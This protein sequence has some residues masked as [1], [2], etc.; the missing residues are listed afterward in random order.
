MRLLFVGDLTGNTGPAN[1]N[2]ELN[3]NLPSSTIFLEKKSIISRILELAIKTKKADAVLF[4]GMSKINI[5]GFKLAKLLGVK[6]AYLM[7]GCRSIE[8]KINGN[9]S[10]NDIDIENKVLE[11]APIIICVSKK[12]MYWMKENYPQYKEK[13]TYVNNGID[14]EQLNTIREGK[15]EREERTLM[16]VG[17]GVPLKNIKSI[18][19][20]IDLINR[21]DGM[22][23][24]LIV[25]G[26]DGKDLE[27]ILSFPFVQHYQNVPHDE[28][29]FYYQR[30]KLF[31]QNSSFETFGLAPIEALVNGCD[32]LLSQE[33]GV[34]S[35]ITTL[36]S[37]D[38]IYNNH[39]INEIS[40]KIKL[41][42]SDV[43]N[44]RLING[45]SQEETSTKFAANRVMDILKN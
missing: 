11:L 26:N 35:I 25:I 14:W 10:K 8:G 17:G 40:S 41:L 7:H 13:L 5:I 29:S 43:N 22:N 42:L 4:S 27:E 20:A 44:Q 9:Y 23:L 38:L 6:S 28:M 36:E 32:L 21:K 24:E 15:I 1:V 2:K 16:A 19:K 12:F 33:A 31:V 45:I 37:N 30:A 18:C 34:K 3:K 39:D